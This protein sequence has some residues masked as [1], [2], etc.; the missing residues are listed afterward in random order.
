MEVFV[1]F[2]VI[3]SIIEPYCMS[4][5]FDMLTYE[6]LPFVSNSDPD[7]RIGEILEFPSSPAF[8]SFSFWPVFARHGSSESENLPKH[9][10]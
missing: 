1:N 2:K 8:C 10:I 3:Q 5:C 9:V 4:V 6:K 7:W